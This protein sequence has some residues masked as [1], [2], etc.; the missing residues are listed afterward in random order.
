[1]VD[2]ATK[3]LPEKLFMQYMETLKTRVNLISWRED[4]GHTNGETVNPMMSSPES[5]DWMNDKSQMSPVG[6]IGGVL[7]RT[8]MI[9]FYK[10]REDMHKS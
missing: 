4:V 5:P 6:I 1:M 3:N 8:Q 7:W 10:G 9:R 2:E